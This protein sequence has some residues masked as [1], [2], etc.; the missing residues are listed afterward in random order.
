MAVKYSNPPFI[1]MK[2]LPQTKERMKKITQ[3][4]IAPLLLMMFFA[5]QDNMQSGYSA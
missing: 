1:N 3:P 2:L 4:N 5:L